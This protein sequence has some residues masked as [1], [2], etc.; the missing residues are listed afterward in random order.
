MTPDDVHVR[1]AATPEEIAAVLAAL[2]ER[3]RQDEKLTRYERWRR[4]RIR[5][6]RDNR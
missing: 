1:G 3:E 2:R 6:L 4:D 5:A